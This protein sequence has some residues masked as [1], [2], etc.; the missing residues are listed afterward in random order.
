[1]ASGSGIRRQFQVELTGHPHYNISGFE[2]KK[3]S[4]KPPKTSRKS[5]EIELNG[6]NRK[7]KTRW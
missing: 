1:M 6:V 3:L 2:I 5:Q 7:E 4:R